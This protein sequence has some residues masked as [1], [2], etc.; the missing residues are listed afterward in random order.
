[1]AAQEQSLLNVQTNLFG[2]MVNVE[3]NLSGTIRNVEANILNKLNSVVL[4]ESNETP[5]FVT[6][7]LYKT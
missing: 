5:L 6:K 4:G 1:M 7:P 3:N 2:S